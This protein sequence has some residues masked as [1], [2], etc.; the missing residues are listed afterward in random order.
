VI[1]VAL[2]RIAFATKTS[3]VQGALE[4]LE[5]LMR[6]N[7]TSRP[8]SLSLEAFD[9]Q[10]FARGMFETCAD[11]VNK[12]HGHNGGRKLNDEDI[13]KKVS[14]HIARRLN[15]NG[16]VPCDFV[17]CASVSRHGSHDLRPVE[18]RPKGM[19]SLIAYAF[20]EE[21]PKMSLA[22]WRR[23]KT[24]KCKVCGVSFRHTKKVVRGKVRTTCDGCRKADRHK[25]RQQSLKR[26][27]L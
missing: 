13:C 2:E 3:D 12:G 16:V 1:L 21:A 6:A 18:V 27:G 19:V 9:A 25:S 7:V 17:Y 20:W 11:I 4:K 8:K 5:R 26:R 23:F 14:A 15:V 10:F 24:I 22:D